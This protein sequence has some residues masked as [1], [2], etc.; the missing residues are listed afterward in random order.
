MLYITGIKALNIDN[1][2]DT[3]GDWHTSALDW[4]T[5]E[6]KESRNT[7]FG[8]WGIEQDKEIPE[9][10]EL[11]NV[12]NDLR[13]I[14]DMMCEGKIRYLKN[15]RNDFICTDKY[16]REFFEK[17]S[18]LRTNVHWEDIDMLMKNEFMFEWINYN[19]EV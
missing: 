3:C 14:L 7:V 15:F 17:V 4:S 10:K 18:I 1:S 9:H 13:A 6:L 12:A 19:K 11:Y 5:V 16:N 2:L 8:D